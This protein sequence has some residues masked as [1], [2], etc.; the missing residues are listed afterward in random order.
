MVEEFLTLSGIGVVCA[1]NGAT[2]LRALEAHGPC[3]ILLDLHMPIM[4]GFGFRQHQR[5]LVSDL[6]HVP[7]VLM[8]AMPSL[9]LHARH[10]GAVDL[11]TKPVDLDRML[12]IV[13]RYSGDR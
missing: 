7:V 11:L 13:R 2:G 10:L 8:S 6:A 3:Q 9:E 1:E 4:D 12:S 5:R